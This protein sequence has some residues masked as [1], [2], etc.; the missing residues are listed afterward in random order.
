MIPSLDL[1]RLAL[2]K[3]MKTAF[4]TLATG[5]YTWISHNRSIAPHSGYKYGPNVPRSFLFVDCDIL[6]LKA[7]SISMPEATTEPK[8]YYTFSCIYRERGCDKMVSSIPFQTQY[9]LILRCTGNA[10]RSGVSK[11]YR[12]S[13]F[14][15]PAIKLA[16]LIR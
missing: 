1:C 2:R 6:P 7:F 3:P 15:S 9:F 13:Y 14:R 5:I 8:Q 10:K 12:M 4:S 11:V 16:L